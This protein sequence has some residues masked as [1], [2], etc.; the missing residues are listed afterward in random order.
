MSELPAHYGMVQSAAMLHLRA[1]QS[2]GREVI[3]AAHL[4][5]LQ[6]IFVCEINDRLPFQSKLKALVELEAAGMIEPMK[7][8]FASGIPGVPVVCTGWQLTHKGRRVANGQ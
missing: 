5:I 7:R 3:K 4:K 2:G 6:R 1:V 8:N